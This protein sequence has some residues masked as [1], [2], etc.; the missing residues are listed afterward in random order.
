[1]KATVLFISA[2]FIFTSV[3][4]QTDLQQY[5]NERIKITRHAMLVLCSW[6]TANAIA[7]TIGIASSQGETKYF[8]QMNL[9]WGATNILIALPT[10]LSLKNRSSNLSLSETVKQQSA[11]EKTFLFN[12]GLDLVYLTAGA[13][14]LEKGN[15]DSKHDL[16]RGYGKS[17][18][19]QGGG[20]LIFDITMSLININHGKKLYKLLNAL[21]ISSNS[22]GVIWKL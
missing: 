13:Y 9:I 16:Y 2:I 6:G 20:L 11:I 15:N 5:N 1:M 4:C 10:Y 12:A 21:Q 8:H 22:A 19:M 17:L 18:L 7:G 3:F 14:C